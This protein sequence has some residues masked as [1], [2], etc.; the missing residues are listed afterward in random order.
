[1]IT[2]ISQRVAILLTL[3]LWLP[4]VA[5]GGGGN[6]FCSCDDKAAGSGRGRFNCAHHYEDSIE[7]IARHHSASST[8]IHV[9]K[10]CNSCLNQTLMGDVRCLIP[11][12]SNNTPETQTDYLLGH[13][14]L[15]G[16]SH[17]DIRES[18][19]QAFSRINSILTFQKTVVLL[20]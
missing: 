20:C 1:M 14:F 3:L 19:L 16:T 11:I 12:N 15:F 13:S 10:C 2:R 9:G 5:W 4:V 17:R 18:L 8:Q 7:L 6:V